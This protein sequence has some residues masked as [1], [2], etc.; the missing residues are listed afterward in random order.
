MASITRI[1]QHVSTSLLERIAPRDEDDHLWNALS[2][3]QDWA[4]ITDRFTCRGCKT[5]E[6]TRTEPGYCTCIVEPEEYADVER[7][8]AALRRPLSVEVIHFNRQ[9]L[10]LAYHAQ[11]CRLMLTDLLRDSTALRQDYSHFP[12]ELL[13]ELA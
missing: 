11:R 7:L 10:D 13:Q 9:R 1:T 6:H 8:S 2:E 4:A 5:S 3:V 12:E